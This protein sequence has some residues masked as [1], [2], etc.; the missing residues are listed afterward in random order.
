MSSGGDLDGNFCSSF[1]YSTDLEIFQFTGDKYFVCWD[2]D[3]VPSRVVEVALSFTSVLLRNTQFS[4]V[5]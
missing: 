1:D 5:L 2:P 3:L 4:L